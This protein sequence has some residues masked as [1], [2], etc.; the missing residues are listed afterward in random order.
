MSP[1]ETA[2]RVEVCFVC[3]G[4][5]CRSPTAAGIMAH[6]VRQ[7]G[8]HQAIGVDSAGTAG[9]HVGDLPDPRA[10]A[11]ARRRGADI[12]DPARQFSRADLER[13]DLVLAMDNDN[14]A[15]LEHLAGGDPTRAR[16]ALLRSFDPAAPPGAEV[17]DPYYGGD[18]GFA[19][20]FELVGGRLLGPTRARGDHLGPPARRV[21]GRH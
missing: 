14:L 9:Y 8:L 5:I 20:V 10:R 12:D 15:R 1:K 2:T 19:E 11:E 16:L 13:F 21:A 7:H 18:D 6:L 4:N 17:P 3:L